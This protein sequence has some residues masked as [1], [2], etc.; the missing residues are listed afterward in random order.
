MAKNTAK[1]RNYKV[2]TRASPLALKQVDEVIRGLER[3]HPDINIEIVCIETTG[4]K[5]K[6]TPISDMEGSDFFT[7]EIDE[8]LLKG[9]I[10]FAIHSAK[11]LADNPREGLA[12]AAITLSICPYDVLVSKFSLKFEELPYKSKVG[13]SSLRRKVQLQIFR[14]DFNIVDVRGNVNERLRQLEE[15]DLDAIVIAGAGLMRLGLE[16]RITQIIP[17]EILRPHP[18]QG[19]LALV[20]RA[21]ELNLV[22][23]LSV[24]DNRG[25]VLV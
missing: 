7:R 25:T 9:E 23:I 2:G 12:I 10:D 1:S 5:D 16:H 11:D 8:A 6:K 22:K 17:L 4:D 13:T 24:L 20:T 21:E 18:L 14:D 19:A 15:S 3:F